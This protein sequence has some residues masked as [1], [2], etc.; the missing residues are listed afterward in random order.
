MEKRNNFIIYM[1]LFIT[2]VLF[3]YAF[4]STINSFFNLGIYFKVNKDFLIFKRDI[5]L[6]QIDDI[7]IDRIV[8]FNRG[9]AEV[10]RFLGDY[11]KGK[12]EVD[13][14]LSFYKE[15]IILDPFY[16]YDFYKKQFNIYD[17][18]GKNKEKEKLLLFLFEKIKKSNYAPNFSAPLAKE[19]YLI[20]Q[21]YL[22]DDQW[23]ETVF[24][25][26]KAI[27]IMPGWSYFYVE[28]ASLYL[29]FSREEKAIMVLKNC[30]AFPDARSHCQEFLNDGNN[31]IYNLTPV[32]SWCRE[33]FSIPDL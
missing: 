2:L 6:R 14:A 1:F 29:E 18:L 13:K 24:W 3:F 12:N 25:W 15:A 21:S 30:L 22:S 28:T 31:T 27:E 33:I 20:G 9:E 7:T 17:R 19:M 26:H 4:V 11:F 8:F 16:N 10:Y 23:E 32:G 5:N